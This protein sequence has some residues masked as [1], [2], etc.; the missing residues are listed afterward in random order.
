[1]VS[2]TRGLQVQL[3]R[4]VNGAYTVLGQVNSVRWFDEQWV[5][6][7]L[8][9]NG[10][11]LRAQLYRPDTGQYLN[12]SGQWHTAPAWALALADAVLTG[13]GLAGRG[14]RASYTGTV[15]FDDFTV[16]LPDI[17]EN[18]DGTAAGSLPAD[19]SQWSSSGK[20]SLA[21]SSAQ[22]LSAPNG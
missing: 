8:V 2:V 11:S 14:Q 1:A 22:A 19:W 21:V 18:F 20:P 10:S 13:G 16:V 12:G 5:R 3:V 17:I 4:V 15:A 7:T 9:V 6:T